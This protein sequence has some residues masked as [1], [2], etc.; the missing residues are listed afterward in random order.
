[1]IVEVLNVEDDF[2][3]Q[4]SQ[5]LTPDGPE[6]HVQ[7]IA[8]GP[9]DC[10]NTTLVTRLTRTQQKLLLDIDGFEMSLPCV[11]G[12]HFPSST[13]ALPG[14]YATYDLT[15]S[16]DDV[17]MN[18]GLLTVSEQ[19][20]VLELFRQ[21]GVSLEN[22]ELRLINDKIAWGY[23]SSENDNTVDFNQVV[24]T[25]SEWSEEIGKMPDG[26]YGYFEVWGGRLDTIYNAQLPSV[27][28]KKMILKSDNI[29]GWKLLR[30]YL[31]EIQEIYPDLIYHF[32]RWDGDVISG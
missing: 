2:L 22:S 19:K 5:L 11:E 17:V 10:L 30:L 9:Q 18:Q 20:V 31:G 29:E 28:Q 3:L 21:E 12:E 16:L 24:N 27:Q 13:H 7:L 6:A 8:L 15:V 14:S 32:T 1:M 23:L 25:I 4:P 26:Y